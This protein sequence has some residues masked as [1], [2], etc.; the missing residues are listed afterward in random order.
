[1]LMIRF[2]PSGN[3]DAFYLEGYKST[4]SAP[5]WISELGL[6][7]F[8]YSFGHGVRMSKE[9]A[10]KIGEEAKKYS[11]ALSV[12][13]PYYINLCAKWKE[14][15][16]KNI[17]HV[18]KSVEAASYMGADRVV[19]HSGSV[20]KISRESGLE[21]A[22]DGLAEILEIKK[23]MGYDNI[24]LCLETMGKTNQLGTVDEVM[25]LCKIDE[26]LLPTLDFGHIDA[27]GQG[28]LKTQEDY[29]KVFDAVEN[30]IGFDRMCSTHVHF[31]RIEH[32]KA[33][34]KKHWTLDDVQYGPDFEPLA[35]ELAKRRITPRI[36]CESRCT[37]AHD[38]V[39]LKK[40]YELACETIGSGE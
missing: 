24:V 28:A 35:L 3:S 2:G 20:A 19:V 16:E 4:V 5:K 39:R 7:A 31:S 23:A 34:E 9:T 33:G 10:M 37:M 25:E 1:M 32:T 21:I 38:A 11:I 15:R 8:E 12:H 14:S 29:A 18:M 27:R 36:I 40:M 13:S 6:N 22:K 26:T 30:A 17:N